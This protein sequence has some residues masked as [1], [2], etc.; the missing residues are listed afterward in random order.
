MTF[1][2]APILTR[3]YS[4]SDFGVYSVLTS[5]TLTLGTVAALRYELAVL[6]PE[7][8][9]DALSLVFVGALSAAV[10]AVLGTLTVLFLG[11]EIAGAFQQPS[12]MPWLWFVPAMSA[13]MA[14]WVL[15]NQ[16]AVRQQRYAASGRRSL[17]QSV[18]SAGGQIG[19][20]TAGMGP[21]GLLGGFGLGQLAASVSLSRGAGITKSLARAALSSE[22]TRRP[23]SRF[24]APWGSV[25]AIS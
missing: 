22:R 13:L 3:L 21:G 2:A 15:M 20:S 17:M 25:L 10:I 4:P 6:L 18:V 1:L 12:L 16:L 9:R 8:D 24:S 14:S 19:L 11:P 5:I 23:T 7:S